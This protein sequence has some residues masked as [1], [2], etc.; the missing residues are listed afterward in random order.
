M[1]SGA[2][3]PGRSDMKLPQMAV[4]MIRMIGPDAAMRM[5]QSDH[6]GGKTITIP[7]GELGR[8]EQTF[9]ALAEVIGADNVK[10][11]CA[12]F[13]GNDIYIPLLDKLRLAERNRKIVAAY[14]KGTSVSQLATA[15]KMSDRQIRN[16]LKTTD[17]T[18]ST[19]NIMQQSLF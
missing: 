2:K 1:S 14:N 13:G 16:I 18:E 4:V 5:M 12:R 8:G 15:N 6:F 10:L 19:K 17:M 3:L 11:L 9:A 7:K